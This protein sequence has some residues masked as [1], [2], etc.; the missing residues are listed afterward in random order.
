MADINAKY[1]KNTSL[2]LDGNQDNGITG[3]FFSN[4]NFNLVQPSHAY[5]CNQ[6]N[7]KKRLDLAAFPT[8]SCI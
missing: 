8:F 3:D 4:E 2:T 5:L 1:K 6:N 7:V